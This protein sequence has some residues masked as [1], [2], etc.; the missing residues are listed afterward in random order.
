[1]INGQIDYNVAR[2]GDD[3]VEFINQEY[4]RSFQQRADSPNSIE[5]KVGE[6]YGEVSNEEKW[7][8]DTIC[9]RLYYQL[10]CLTSD[11][12]HELSVLYE[13]KIKNMGNAGKNE[14]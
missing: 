13:A 1:M 6:V 14:Y 5:Y 2:T 10:N 8:W 12:R 7:T 9:N 11:D 3:L 4:F